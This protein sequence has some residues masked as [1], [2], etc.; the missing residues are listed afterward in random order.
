MENK[1]LCKSCHTIKPKDMFSTNHGKC[2]ECRRIQAKEIYKQHAKPKHEKIEPKTK[3]ICDCGGSYTYCNKSTHLKTEKHIEMMKVLQKAESNETIELKATLSPRS[4]QHILN[5]IEYFNK[6]IKDYKNTK[7][8]LLETTDLDEIND[9]NNNLSYIQQDY[10][11]NKYKLL[12]MFKIYNEKNN[13]TENQYDN[14]QQCFEV[15]QNI[16]TVSNDF[17]KSGKVLREQFDCESDPNLKDELNKQLISMRTK[18]A[19]MKITLMK[20]NTIYNI[21]YVTNCD[22]ALVI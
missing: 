18:H 4:D 6:I 12:N 20:C 8:M 21:K 1:K 17:V 11:Q 16:K 5:K 7:E 22:D 9:L 13:I 14:K 3:Y 2:K 15:V 10:T 19:D